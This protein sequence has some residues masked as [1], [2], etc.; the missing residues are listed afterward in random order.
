MKV[1]KRIV[2]F[3]LVFA[4]D[5]Y[6]LMRF[7]EIGVFRDIRT[8]WVTT[9]MTTMTHQ[10]LAKLLASDTQIYEIME[11]NK[12]DE[13]DESEQ[14]IIEAIE[15]DALKRL[16]AELDEQRDKDL[17]A[18]GY[19]RLEDG[20]YLKSVN[21]DKFAAKLLLITDPRRIRVGLTRTPGKRGDLVKQMVSDNG[22]IAGINGGWF[23]DPNY[24]GNGGIPTGYV[25]QQGNVTYEHSTGISTIAGFN[26][27]GVLVIGNYTAKAALAEGIKEAMATYPILIYNGQPKI[28]KGDGGWGIAPRTAI[29]QRQ[30]GEVLMLAIDGRQIH[31]IGAT[32]RQVQDLL[33]SEGAWTAIC[34]DG[35]SSTVMYYGDDYVN[36]P[37]LGHE[38]YIPTCWLVMPEM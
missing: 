8:L 21:I 14:Q 10:W 27:D 12:I 17:V 3:A 34:L 22:A 24:E 37:S 6:C 1:F 26:K 11:E 33:L 16:E 25:I 4:I 7:S 9:A 13:I 31:S 20:T 18:R 2:I 28:T 35:G 32:L 38:R 19:T 36:K 30:T 29:A 5:T 15:V 23:V